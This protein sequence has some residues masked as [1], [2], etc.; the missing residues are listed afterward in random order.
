MLLHTKSSP[1]QN[2]LHVAFMS[3]R[4]NNFLFTKSGSPTPTPHARVK[5][6]DT[7]ET[8]K[9]DPQNPLFLP[10]PPSPMGLETQI[11]WTDH[12]CMS[13]F[14]LFLLLQQTGRELLQRN[15]PRL[16]PRWAGKIVKSANPLVLSEN[17]LCA[18]NV[19]PCRT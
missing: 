5:C 7:A 4:Q 14:G 17:A 1:L 2:L 19:T 18:Q 16:M 6:G 12:F 11:L 9:K 13:R 10:P 3:R 8:L 15:F